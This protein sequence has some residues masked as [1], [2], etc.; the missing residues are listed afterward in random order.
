MPSIFPP[1]LVLLLLL[2][3]YVCVIEIDWM[4]Q[5]RSSFKLRM[6]YC[7]VLCCAGTCMRVRHGNNDQARCITKSKKKHRPKQKA[8]TRRGMKR[9][10]C[11][12]SVSAVIITGSSGSGSSRLKSNEGLENRS[13]TRR[14][15]RRRMRRTDVRGREQKHQSLWI[16]PVI[17]L[18]ADRE[19]RDHHQPL[20]VCFILCCTVR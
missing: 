1:S 20:N 17:I 6:W 14:R 4:I 15:G 11:G 7:S 19:K 9:G 12:W 3:S 2:F 16:R 8:W 5:S 10:S 13:T 18:S